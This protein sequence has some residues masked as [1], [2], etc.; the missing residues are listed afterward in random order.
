MAL[1]L[2]YAHE[3]GYTPYTS[4]LQEAWRV[5]LQGLTRAVVQALDSQDARPEISSSLALSP[6]DP[7]DPLTGFAVAAARRHRKRGITLTLFLGLFKYYRQ[8]FCDLMGEEASRGPGAPD[9]D[10][11][12]GLRLW[13]NRCFDRMELALTGEWAGTGNRERL[14]ELQA[15]NRVLVNEKNKFLTLAESLSLPL[16]LTDARGRLDYANSA[17]MRL[18]DRPG[19]PGA[20]YYCP[21]H[22]RDTGQARTA[23]TES[24]AGARI[25]DVA[26]WLAP[27]LADF[28]ESGRGTAT[29]EKRLGEGDGATVFHVNLQRMLDVSGKFEGV[30][31]TCEDV[32]RMHQAESR[33]RFQ[34]ALLSSVRQGVVATDRD[35]AIT[36][37]GPGAEALYGYSAEE[38]V[39]RHISFLSPAEHADHVAGK[40]AAVTERG[41]W[42]G[43]V[44][45][46]RKDGTRCVSEVHISVVPGRDGKP[47]GFIGFDHDVTQRLRTEE[48]LKEYRT[49]VEASQDLI[50]VLD[51]EHR[52]RLVNQAYCDRYNLSRDQLLGMSVAELIDPDTYEREVR[53]R[54]DTAFSGRAVSYTLGLDHPG[55]PDRD[56]Q[57]QYFPLDI[58]ENGARRVVVVVRDVT[59]QARAQEALRAGEARL[60]EAQRVARIGSFEVRLPDHE[61]HWSA[62]FYRILGY[63]PMEFEPT[64]QAF[65]ERIHPEDADL[66]DANMEE[67]LSRRTVF[68]LEFRLLTPTGELRHA[69]LQGRVE[70]GE[71]G[72]WRAFGTLQDITWRKETEAELMRESSV[73]RAVASLARD[74]NS[75]ETD[76]RDMA[77]LT[78]DMARQ[79][80]GAVHGYVG[81]IDPVTGELVSHTLTA[82]MSEDGC[83]V[84]E[85]GIRFPR[86]PDGYR[87][88]YGHSLN[89]GRPFFTNEAATHR[90]ARGLPQGHVPVRRFLSVPA[91]YHGRLLGQVSLANPGRD[92]TQADLEAVGVMADLFAMAVARARTRRELVKSK[93]AAQEASR[94][95]SEFLATMSHELRTPLNGIM[96]MLQLMHTTQVTGEQAE[97][98]D[99][100]MQASRNLTRLLGDIL[101]ITKVEA[102]KLTLAN[103]IFRPA[104]I[105]ETMSQTFEPQ[106]GEKGLTLRMDLDP[107]TPDALAGDPGRLRQI[108]FNLLANAVKFTPQGDVELSV[109]PLSRVRPGRQRLL[110][111]VS[112]TGIGMSDEDLAKV[113]DPFTQVDGSY[114]RRYGGSGLG[115][116]IV[117]RLVSLMGGHLAVETA[118]E[119]GTCVSLALEFGLLPA[120]P[121]REETGRPLAANRRS[122][123]I[124]V[125]ED[126]PLNQAV[127]LRFLDK[128]GHRATLAVNGSQA[129][130]VLEDS[131]HDVVFMDVRMPGLDGVEA[132][133]R[134]RSGQ[135][136]PGA[137]RIPIVAM[138]AHAMSGDRERF[139]AAGMD[140]YMAK[141]VDL[142]GLADLLDRLADQPQT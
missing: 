54:L 68:E 38:A 127:L 22:D 50:A 113:F 109:S 120:E 139:L 99:Q 104:D 72:A 31:A 3:H 110:F 77:Q 128:L 63:E 140:E 44:P 39:G 26:P 88:L 92:F 106:A 123:R 81:S 91:V 59:E 46:V 53:P 93:E 16:L 122:L 49:A 70:R 134:I 65:H 6:A 119:E 114:T 62:Q 40:L 5:S 66:F 25:Q 86:D 45:K 136:G 101:D 14:E 69:H 96:G 126:D 105:L 43:H 7:A 71:S 55:L 125:A 100:A 52:Y 83:R 107:Q 4:T 64:T 129:L 8:A 78:L 2:G 57:V 61:I 15:T 102:G 60:R 28:A 73:N 34:A 131:P 133:R 90:R 23:D 87:G 74:L 36:Y 94:A 98:L 67:F 12:P 97:F 132:T 112:D 47:E 135:A 124:L 10:R 29:L 51:E 9:P 141:P 79:I 1:L 21:C 84:P 56:L 130:D 41:A 27:D 89:T 37:W 17:F 32:T 18:L 30:V 121:A 19:T 20:Y 33:N 35:G 115:L 58:A 118:P 138:T 80:T 103:E 142:A 42:Q 82:T 95:K 48:I 75:P 85:A 13:L 117:Q 137:S 116:A 76:I 108:L 24:L 11:L 111:T